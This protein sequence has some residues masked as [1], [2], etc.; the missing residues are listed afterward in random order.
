MNKYIILFLYSIIILLLFTGSSDMF[1]SAS[2]LAGAFIEDENAGHQEDFSTS[3]QETPKPSPSPVVPLN[4]TVSIVVEPPPE[5]NKTAEESAPPSSTPEP[6][7]R[8]SALTNWYMS[9]ETGMKVPILMYHNLLEGSAAGDSLNVSAEAFDDQMNQLKARGYNTITFSNLYDHY[10]NGSPLAENPVIITFDDGYESNYTIGYPILKKYGLK[11][12]IFVITDAIGHSNYLD[13]EQ[14]REI[15]SSGVIDVQSH[16]ANHSYYLY[17]D[18]KDDIADE[19][20]RSRTRIEN[21]TGKDVNVFCYTCGKYSQRLVDELI[22]QEYIF[23]VTT[24]YGIASK[25]AH[26]FLLPRIRVMGGDSGKN[27]KTKI[28]KLTGVTT[29]YIGL[30]EETS[31]TEPTPEPAVEPDQS[32]DPHPETNPEQPIDSEQDKFVDEES[33]SDQTIDSEPDQIT[34]PNPEESDIPKEE[35]ESDIKMDIDSEDTG[36]KIEPESDSEIEHVPDN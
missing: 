16:S 5:N 21:I 23:S 26:P 9:N 1:N 10:M 3:V 27:L 15:A 8:I 28:T 36:L 13:E 12:C 4:T 35:L 31:T 6:Q 7:P 24:K 2:L 29:K 25:K 17:S 33:E 34:G 22:E 14:I 20:S 11:A 30:P 19:L 18:S 32:M